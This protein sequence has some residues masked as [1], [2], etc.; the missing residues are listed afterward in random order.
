MSRELDSLDL[1]SAN[2][3]QFIKRSRRGNPFLDVIENPVDKR[4]GP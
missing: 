1:L 2:K 4:L 3:T